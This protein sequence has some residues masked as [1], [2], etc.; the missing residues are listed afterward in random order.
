[1]KAELYNVDT[2]LIT[3]HTVVRRFRENEGILLYPLIADN[4]SRLG[5]H[6]SVTLHHITS[7]EIAEFFVRK[8]IA[9]W[10]LQEEYNFGVWEKDTAKLIGFI[11]IFNIDWNLPKGEVDFFIDRGYTQMGTMTEVLRAITDFGFKQ[12]KL[13]KLKLA[14]SIDNQAAQRLARKC[15]YRREGDLRSEMK[16]ENG[17]IIDVMVF[18]LTKTEFFGMD[19]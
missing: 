14:I 11:R 13:E 12:L 15:H 10:I 5:E 19:S 18:G 16:K 2:A 3:E 4:Y 8:K 7:K 1:M 9:S 6:F 17:E